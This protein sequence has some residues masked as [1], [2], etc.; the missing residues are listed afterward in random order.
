MARAVLC[1]SLALASTPTLGSD[2]LPADVFIKTPQRS[3]SYENLYALSQGELWVKPNPRQAPGPETWSLFEGT[4][5]PFGKKAASFRAGDSLVAFATEG[6]MVVAVS[7]RGRFYVW[8]PTLF[9]PTTWQEKVGSPLPGALMLPADRDWTFSMSVQ[10]AP[11]KRRTPMHD[12]DAFYEDG[13]GN[14]VE[15]GFTATVYVLDP[16]GQRIRYWDTGLPPAFYKAFATPERGRFVAERLSAAGSTLFVVDREGRMYTRMMDYEM[17][18]ACPGLRYT[19]ERKKQ[20]KADEILPMFEVERVLPLDGWRAQ[21]PI[22]LDAS[23]EL[24]TRISIHLTGQGNAARELR[25]QG[26]NAQG[27]YG[28]WWKP[29]F[30]PTWRFQPTGESYP[31]SVVTSRA[32]SGEPGRS[33][34]KTY[35]GTLTQPGVPEVSVELVDFDYYDTP[36]TLRLHQGALTVDVQLHTFD[37]WGPTAEQKEHPD[38]VGSILGEPKLLVGTLEVPQELLESTDPATRTLV[39]TYLRRFHRV[40]QAFAIQADDGRVELHARRIQRMGTGSLQYAVR[41]PLDVIVTRE[42]SADEM[43]RYE[44]TNFTHLAESPALLLPDAKSLGPADLPRVEEVLG[45][46]R[47][48]LAELERRGLKEREEHLASGAVSALASAVFVPLNVLSDALGLPSDNPMAGGLAITGGH[49]LKEYAAMNLKRV[50]SNP[51]DMRRAAALLK[52]RIRAYE[53]LT[54]EL[55]AR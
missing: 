20:G 48:L 25:V 31:P 44:D 4:G 2:E 1:L 40:H 49:V 14:R 53:A 15:F 8:Q 29:I 23:A 5:V 51:E 42:V 46:N 30:D 6:L 50:I 38:L 9:E 21:E 54:R 43:A 26:R 37:A 35:T 10:T 11:K 12:I 47:A 16:D 34:D 24:T 17:N 22:P 28:Y 3:F 55:K 52:K 33:L 32:P 27:A 39:D 41:R 36:A 18:G 19:F 7:N 13:V 45:R